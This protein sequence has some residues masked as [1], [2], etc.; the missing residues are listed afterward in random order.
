MRTLLLQAVV[1]EEEPEAGVVEEEVEAEVVEGELPVVEVTRM[2]AQRESVAT[3]GRR[4]S[5]L[6]PTYSVT[7]HYI[8]IFT[9]RSSSLL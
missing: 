5:L 3:A 9:R 6:V 8:V 4:V 1:S 7:L 2:P